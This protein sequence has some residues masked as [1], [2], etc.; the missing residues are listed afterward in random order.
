MVLFVRLLVIAVRAMSAATLAAVS[1]FQVVLFRK[2]TIAL[3][4]E[5]VVSRFKWDF[6]LKKTHITKLAFSYL[7]AMFVVVN[8]FILAR[9]FDG[10]VLWPF[11][12]VRKKE[13]KKDPVFMN[14]ER[15]HIRQQTELLVVFFFIWYLTEYLVRLMICRNSYRAYNNISFER[16]A[17]RYE[18]DPLYL[19]KRRFWSFLRF[20]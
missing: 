10:V 15:I 11:I 13:L 6:F 8:K 5:I 20:L 18:E 7:A 2:T 19:K 14:H 17:Y 4:G 16:E 3:R 1:S 12:I 9:H